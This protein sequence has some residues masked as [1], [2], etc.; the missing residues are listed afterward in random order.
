MKE[1][2]RFTSVILI[3]SGMEINDVMEFRLK[4]SRKQKKNETLLLQ[5]KN[6]QNNKK[7]NQVFISVS[8]S[9]G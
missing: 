8:Q 4:Q 5:T 7:L 2:G 9:T 3:S 6:Y 1:L